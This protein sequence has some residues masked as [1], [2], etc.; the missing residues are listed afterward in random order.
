VG[1]VHWSMD[2]GGH[3]ETRD[4]AEWDECIAHLEK[5]LELVPLAM[6]PTW[7]LA[8]SY[9]RVGRFDDAERL[10]VVCCTQIPSSGLCYFYG[11]ILERNGRL[12]EAAAG[13]ATIP[14]L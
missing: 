3:D 14:E 11:Q 6:V 7:N 13:K 10:Y 9:F 4:A 8:L 2:T 5:A 12:Q 1:P